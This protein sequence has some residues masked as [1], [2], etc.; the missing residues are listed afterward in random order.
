MSMSLLPFLRFSVIAVICFLPALSMP[1]SAQLRLAGENCDFGM[2]Q[3]QAGKQKRRIFLVNEGP[4]EDCILRVRPTCGCTAADF[5]KEVVMPGDSAWIDIVYDPKG[6]PGKINKGVRVYRSDG[7]VMLI[8][9]SGVV[10]GTP[11]TL[12]LSYPVEAGPLRL[13]EDTI[14]A[15]ELKK[16]NA[17]HIFIN[18]YNAS[19]HPVTPRI[20]CPE[21]PD[22]ALSLD[23]VPEVIPPGE[24][25]TVSFYLNSRFEERTGAVTYDISLYPDTDTSAPLSPHP[26]QLRVM[27]T[28]HATPPAPLR[29]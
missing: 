7:E 3:E 24:I 11:E 1:V 25:G 8:P 4:A 27:L 12:S 17:R 20:T 19:E 5:S 28:P 23:I 21:A 15:G 22:K 6:R 9:L 2:I 13:S 10:I 18:A 14:V 26:I 29:H 16:G